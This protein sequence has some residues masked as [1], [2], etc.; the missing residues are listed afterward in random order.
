MGKGIP[1]FKEFLRFFT[2]LLAMMNAEEK[3]KVRRE[4]VRERGSE[5]RARAR[6]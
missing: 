4:K 1:R 5:A 3:E 2:V 6:G